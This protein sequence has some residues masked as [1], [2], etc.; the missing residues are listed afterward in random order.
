MFVPEKYDIKINIKNE[1]E[2]FRFVG[3]VVAHFLLCYILFDLI[4]YIW[5]IPLYKFCRIFFVYLTAVP[6][7]IYCWKEKITLKEQLA[8]TSITGIL[9]GVA[10]GVG[11]GLVILVVSKTTGIFG[12]AIKYYNDVFDL[13]K[14][15]VRGYLCTALVE[16]YVFRVS[17]YEGAKKLFGGKEWMAAIISALLF[18]IAH[19]LDGT[20]V[21]VVLNVT[22]GLI[23]GFVKA[24]VKKANFATFVVA[25]GTYNFFITNIDRLFRYM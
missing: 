10:L 12:L 22:H 24:Y 8:G 21:K 25:H 2:I 13:L 1:K 20:W 19:I 18:G 3:M 14:Y 16:E 6:S 23:L 5:N 17:I 9:L 7:V 15:I 11:Y 4:D